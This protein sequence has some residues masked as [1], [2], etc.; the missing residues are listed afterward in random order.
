[1]TPPELPEDIQS[2]IERAL[3][4]DI[5]DGDRNAALVERGRRV[6]AELVARESAVLAGSPWFNAT[7]AAI[8][9][10]VQVEW[11]YADGQRVPK[12]VPLCTLQG[13]ARALLSGERT[14]LNFLQMM[15]GIASMTYEYVERVK[16][17]RTAIVDTRKTLPGL[18]SAQKYAVRCG[19]G[20]N[21]RFGLFD[22]ILIK[23]NHIAAA[24]SIDA[25]VKRAHEMS[26]ELTLQVE[27]ETLDELD[28]TL[29]ADVQSNVDAILLDNLATHVL[30]RAVNMA[31]A[32]RQRFRHDIMIEASG[33]INLRNVREIADT[34][35]D[36]I[37]IG[38]LTKN[39][40][41][42]DFS[43][44]MVTEPAE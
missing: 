23:E 37:S 14:A 20:E 3:L 39:V 12:D 4:E 18:R 17:T 8:D 28:Q 33:D 22:A 43:I 6:R 40:R 31:K 26:P 10:Q 2:T 16:G 29:E 32:H 38:G 15:S 41:A 30:A 27:V 11:H 9:P 19:G 35:V 36:R 5:G 1:M 21:H 25:A 13:P 42:T 34:G 7:F 44:R 24:G